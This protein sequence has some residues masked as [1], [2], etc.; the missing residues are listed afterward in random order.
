MS[1]LTLRKDFIYKNIHKGCKNI[2]EIILG[3]YIYLSLFS[4]KNVFI[5]N[6]NMHYLIYFTYNLNLNWM[7]NH[8]L[9]EIIH[10]V[11]RMLQLPHRD[12][13]PCFP[14]FNS[15]ILFPNPILLYS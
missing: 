3:I 15:R 12:A 13:K 6:Y 7:S 4:F 1:V 8:F 11:I 10:I 9:I 14:F 2:I 5:L